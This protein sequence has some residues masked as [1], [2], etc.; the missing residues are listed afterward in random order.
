MAAFC[1]LAS[2]LLPGQTTASHVYEL[3]RETGRFRLLVDSI[4]PERPVLSVHSYS[5]DRSQLVLS[6]SVAANGEEL[7]LDSRIHLWNREEATSREVGPGTQATW[8]DDRRLVRQ[9][10]TTSLS[11]IVGG[12]LRSRII[13]DDLET[14]SQEIFRG[15][16]LFVQPSPALGIEL[17]EPAALAGLQLSASMRNLRVVNGTHYLQPELFDRIDDKQAVVLLPVPSDATWQVATLITKA[18]HT[19]PKAA[20]ETTDSHAGRP[21]AEATVVALQFRGGLQPN[22]PIVRSLQTVDVRRNRFGRLVVVGGSLRSLPLDLEPWGGLQSVNWL[23]TSAVP[24]ELLLTISPGLTIDGTPVPNR[25]PAPTWLLAVRGWDRTTEDAP[26]TIT[27]LLRVP[28]E[29]G[30]PSHPFVRN[31]CASSDGR[32]VAFGSDLTDRQRPDGS[33]FTPSDFRVVER[34]VDD[35]AESRDETVASPVLEEFE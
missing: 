13:V 1:L 25:A 15:G 6:A 8:L 3:D 2:L 33:F 9:V 32:F 22:G 30:V 10:F 12:S 28:A 21:L 7:L 16:G 18:S 17:D 27:P 31:V 26:P 14:Q 20:A 23:S 11:E 24:G 4:D 29:A 19:R 34:P 35:S 5:P